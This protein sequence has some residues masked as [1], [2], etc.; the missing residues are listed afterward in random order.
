L[1]GVIERRTHLRALQALLRQFPVVAILGSRQVGK[2]TLA[3]RLGDRIGG[4]VTH[5]DLENPRDLARL[6]DPMLALEP[7]RG[8]VI[9]DET[10]RRPE[11]FPVLRVLS[12]RRRRLARFL[13]L[14]SASPDLL[15]Q[16]SESLAGR[17]VHHHLPGFS[18]EEAGPSQIDRLWLRGG[19][20]RSFLARSEAESIRWRREFV[21]TFLERDIPQ[22]GLRLPS[23]T[24]ERCWAMLAHGHGQVQNLSD[25]ARS[26]G[27]TDMTVRRYLDA[28]TSTF[29]VR[30]LRPWHE[31]L[32]KR[33]VRA[34]KAYVADSGL[35]HT[36]LDVIDHNALLRHPRAGA[37]WEGFLLG[38]A[39]QCLGARPENCYFWATHQGAELDLLI[40]QGE[41]RR[42]VEF[43]R[44]TTPAMTRSMHVALADL[45]LDRLDV[46]HA[47][48][49]TFPLA[50]RVRAVAAARLLEDLPA[51]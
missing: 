32:A 7:L 28:L 21:R 46:V 45:R 15:R 50:T 39:V 33:Q 22:L 24:L 11:L 44:T 5:F 8:V 3:R 2:T 35:L 37:S 43:K 16:S 4:S 40:V 30:Q 10:Q 9:L 26:L 38:Q 19:L 23:T 12:D 31:N 29:M 1:N 17:I 51:R 25:L 13:I 48:P 41:Q 47:G 42:G 18:L 20:P 36:L 14:G 6:S 27:V 34:P 49:D